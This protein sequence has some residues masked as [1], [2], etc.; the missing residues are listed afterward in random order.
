MEGTGP[1][2][3][4]RAGNSDSSR[5][6]KTPVYYQIILFLRSPQFAA[7]IICVYIA[8]FV[9]GIFIPQEGAH[10][11]NAI[12]Q[13][14][15]EAGLWGTICRRLGLLHLQ[16]SGLV[17]ATH[18][19]FFLSVIVCMAH[20]F[21]LAWKW[22]RVKGTSTEGLA[23]S[24]IE[25]RVAIPVKQPDV[26][27][28]EA[29]V[30]LRKLWYSVRV[31]PDGSGLLATKGHLSLLGSAVFHLSFLI[32][33]VAG[34]QSSATHFVGT[35]FVG[36][37]EPFAG[38]REDYTY[39]SSEERLPEISFLVEKIDLSFGDH[40]HLE[41]FVATTKTGDGQAFDIGINHPYYSGA[42]AVYLESSGYA[43]LWVIKDQQGQV[44]DGAYVKLLEIGKEDHFQT[45]SYPCVVFVTLYPDWERTK[46]TNGTRSL[47]LKNPALVI[48]V[49]EQ[50]RITFEGVVRVGE[51]VLLESGQLVF[52]EIIRWG[53]FRIIKDDGTA[54]AFGGF[55]I[56]LLGL[57]L[58]FVRL[59]K[60]IK[61]RLI[62]NGVSRLELTGSTEFFPISFK[63]ELDR[64]GSALQAALTSTETES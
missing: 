38:A 29:E 4:P 15:S 10:S 61:V 31:E 18:I 11:T 43:P 9:L 2:T 48:K 22:L 8:L 23:P 42:T 52:P 30:L 16:K 56:L 32:F 27:L 14:V 1:S 54:T 51:P 53:Q 40:G 35:A 36:E 62:G 37:G 64:I 25:Q 33:A 20:R 46:P 6:R 59:R 44:L 49:V 60:L 50:G 47:E 5:N 39:A 26:S 3:H 28:R 24:G 41:H 57:L 12:E 21:P 13:W 19:A 58:R 17:I 34:L 63:Q 7:A 55:A 45:G